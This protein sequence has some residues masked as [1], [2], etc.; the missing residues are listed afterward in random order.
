MS[1]TKYQ[2]N[3]LTDQE[4]AP[5]IKTARDRLKEREMS[6]CMFGSGGTC[7]RV[8]N[9]GPCQIIDRVDSMIGVCGATSDTV[10]AQNFARAIGVGVSRQVEEAREMVKAFLATAR[11]ESPYAIHDEQRLTE[12]ARHFDID[13]TATNKNDLA[14][15]VG[16]RLLAEFGNQNDDLALMRVAP[17]KRRQIWQ[18]LGVMP[19][20]LDREVV[21]LMHR[22]HMGVDQEFANIIR[23]AS[24]CALADGWG[25][26]RLT[27][28]LTDIMFPAPPPDSFREGGLREDEINILV[29]SQ[30]P[31]AIEALL[32]MVDDAEIKPLLDNSRARGINLTAGS[33]GEQETMLLTGAI[34]VMVV[35]GSCIMPSISKIAQSFHTHLVTCSSSLRMAGAELLELVGPKA[36]DNARTILKMAIAAFPGR[37]ERGS[38]AGPAGDKKAVAPWA[39]P[40]DSSGLT[41]QIKKGNI[42]GIAMVIGCDNYRHQNNGHLLMAERLLKNN[43]LVLTNGCA[44]ESLAKNGMLQGDR[45]KEI[46]GPKLRSACLDLGLEPILPLGTCIDSS[47]LLAIAAS[48][49]EEGLGN[50]LAD[51]PLAVTVPAWTSEKIVATGQCLVASGINA[52]FRELPIAGSSKVANYLQDS[53]QDEYGARWQIEEDPDKL[54]HKLID[55]IEN[56][57]PGLVKTCGK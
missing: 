54:A 57:R 1:L 38:T 35:S 30:G 22:T 40:I 16:E 15:I 29:Y 12:L 21:E 19:R 39:G 7:C 25:A 33:I 14:L 26:S 51:L 17:E 52:F 43:I 41:R 28:W 11:G 47:R 32:T 9:M 31:L 6:M 56:K 34:E 23:Q 24:R 48:L 50:D 3:D 55:L 13:P 2:Q 5:A 46:V 37:G 27:G 10:V 44:A 8:C 49:L 42:R 4:A 18:E 45:T 20:G 36:Q 53:C